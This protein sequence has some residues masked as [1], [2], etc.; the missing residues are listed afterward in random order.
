[1]GII[2]YRTSTVDVISC[3][4]YLVDYFF[5][6]SA[7][8]DDTNLTFSIT[9]TPSIYFPNITINSALPDVPNPRVLV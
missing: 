1:M 6:V 4:I 8:P 3:T 2:S 7:S 9:V 5:F